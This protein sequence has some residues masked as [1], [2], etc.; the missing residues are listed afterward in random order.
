MDLVIEGNM[1]IGGE[2]KQTSIGIEDGIIVTVG[3]IVRGGEERIEFKDK[4]ILPGFIDPHVHFRDPGLTKKEDFRTGTASAVFGGVTCVLDM[5]NTIP[6]VT[7]VQALREKKF[8]LRSKAFTDY[9]LF[10]A[11]TKNSDVTSLAKESV[12]FKLFMGSTTGDI[13]MNDDAFINTIIRKAAATGKVISVHAEDNNLIGHAAERNNHDHLKN[14]PIEAELNAIRRLGAYKGA[15]INICH[16][17]SAGSAAMAEQYGFTT[18]VTA[19]HLLF[20]ETKAGAGYKVNPPLRDENTREMLFKI[21]R[22][23]K[24]S[25]IGS[26]HA[27]HTESEKA[28]DY[29]AAPSG[30]SGVETTMPIMM[31]LAK[32]GMVSLGT[33]VS[34]ASET[35]ARTFGLRKGRIEKGYDADFAIFDIHKI[36]KITADGLHGKNRTSV[37]EGYEVIF[38]ET[39]MVRGNIQIAGGE[40]CGGTIGANVNG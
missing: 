33:L 15:R 21:F 5:P 10:S 34:M 11:L 18:E 22:E 16:I 38:P 20:N 9:G 4:L 39:V 7:D 14:R 35:P 28:N 17:T 25:M 6:P 1:F 2:L 37:Y 36:R 30:I 29:D 13:L 12:G 8:T 23:G 27:P 31:A 19:H 26:D 40:M 3:K 32:K 24:I